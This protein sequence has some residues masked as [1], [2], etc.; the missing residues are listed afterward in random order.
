MWR[1]NYDTISAL[2]KHASDFN[3]HYP[4]SIAYTP[5]PR[6]ALETFLTQ[7]G[8]FHSKPKWSDFFDA[9]FLNKM[10]L[11]MND[12]VYHGSHGVKS[13]YRTRQTWTNQ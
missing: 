5:L 2:Q 8:L 1:R 7:R 11:R 6:A 3:P 4:S 12:I 13:L 9:G 10:Y